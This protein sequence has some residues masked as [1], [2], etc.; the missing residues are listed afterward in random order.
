M[1]TII[2]YIQHC[3]GDPASIIKHKEIQGIEKEKNMIIYLFVCTE[4][5]KE[6]TT[7]N[8]K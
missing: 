3:I 7:R 1:S 5:Q 2:T 6:S 4:N 8:N